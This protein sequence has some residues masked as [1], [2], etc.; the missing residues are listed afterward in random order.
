M[1]VEIS[2]RLGITEEE[3]ADFCQR[4]QIAELSLFGSALRD[5]FRHDSDI[6]LLVR[7]EADARWSLIDHIGI[8]QKL[9]ALLGR[10]VDLSSKTGVE[11]SKNWIIRRNILE[12]AELIYESR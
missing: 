1:R 3:L 7:Y 10:T 9:T 5:D 4:W 12:S 8:E 6:D 11:S 2:A